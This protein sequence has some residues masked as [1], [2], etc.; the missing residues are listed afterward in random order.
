MKYL[1]IVIIA[2]IGN[3]T[4]AQNAASGEWVRNAPHRYIDTNTFQQ[5][6]II[7]TAG[8]DVPVGAFAAP[9]SEGN[10][11]YPSVGYAQE[12]YAVDISFRIPFKNSFS[13][14]AVSFGYQNNPLNAYHYYSNQIEFVPKSPP[15]SF[16]INSYNKPD[17][18]LYNLMIGWSGILVANRFFCELILQAG[19]MYFIVPVMDYNYTQTIYAPSPFPPSTST[20]QV[21]TPQDASYGF[22]AKALFRF[23]FSI[24]RKIFL[25]TEEGICFSKTILLYNY[26]M[27][28]NSLMYSFG[29]GYKF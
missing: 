19:L 4:F 2:L 23:S 17:Y 3:G 14:F 20:Y 5:H 6:F 18:N 22:F 27:P 16:V 8:P 13:A 26:N 9:N 7:L 15:K 11:T 24:T 21:H 1:A 12:G 28:V 29:I 10:Y 25:T